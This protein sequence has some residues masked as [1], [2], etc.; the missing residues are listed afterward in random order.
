MNTIDD[1][2]IQNEPTSLCSNT[3]LSNEVLTV[4]PLN[5]DDADVT[6]NLDGTTSDDEDEQG[7]GS[8]GEEPNPLIDTFLYEEGSEEVI[9][10]LISFFSFFFL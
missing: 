3:E 2:I 4:N 5:F 7:L 8:G 6:N 1:T 10:C 9:R